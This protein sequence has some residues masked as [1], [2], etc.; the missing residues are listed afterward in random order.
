LSEREERNQELDTD[1]IIKQLRAKGRKRSKQIYAN[2]ERRI[3]LVIDDVAMFEPDAED[4][5][6]GKATL[7]QI[8]ERNKGNNLG[9]TY[10]D[11]DT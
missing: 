1:E 4:L 11:D 3:C 2:P 10:L 5:L 6:L 8:V 7:N 9:C